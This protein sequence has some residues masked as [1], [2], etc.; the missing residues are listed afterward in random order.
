MTDGEGVVFALFAPG[1]GVQAIFLANGLHAIPAS[2]E[3]LVGI[4]LM[5][6]IPDQTIHRGLVDIMQGHRQF[7]D[8]ETRGQMATAAADGAQQELPQFIA[9]GGQTLLRQL[10]QFIRSVG[11]GQERVMTNIETHQILL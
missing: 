6:H 7:D 8:A 9:Q 10:P 2:G 5:A 3:D 4:G 11:L 1:E